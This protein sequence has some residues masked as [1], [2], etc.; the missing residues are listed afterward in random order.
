MFK[1]KIA[2]SL[3]PRQHGV[4]RHP[5]SSSAAY[6]GAAQVR[7]GD[8]WYQGGVEE[9]F[10]GVITVPRKEAL[11]PCLL[12]PVQAHIASHPTCSNTGMPFAVYKNNPGRSFLPTGIT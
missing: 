10:G 8:G 4:A 7:A 11:G 6:P 2:R 12:C 5:S 1:V 9:N 3:S